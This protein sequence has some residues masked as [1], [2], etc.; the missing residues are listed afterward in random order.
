MKD[1][2]TPLLEVIAL[3][4]TDARHARDG[5]ADRLELVS[6]MAAAGLS[7]APSTVAAV[8]A[9]TDLP[10]RVMLRTRADFTAG[11]LGPLRRTAKDLRAAGATEFVLG[12][13]T[14]AATVDL[15]AVL[16]LLAVLDGAPWTFHRAI[17]H[18]TDRPAAWAALTGLPGLD[19]VL[20]SG[21][22]AGLRDGLAALLAEAPARPALLA[23]G[24]LRHEHI[25]LLRA[26][27]VTAFHSGTAVREAGAWTGPVDPALVHD[28]KLTLGRAPTGRP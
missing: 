8:R 21:A 17:D 24:G 13:L 9:A 2:I 26:A 25:A 5:G 19:A 3:D 1:M 10:V 22:P 6:D 23:G 20:T 16:E 4:A 12:F 27:G 11:D 28:L 14:P 7:P 18:T 15:P